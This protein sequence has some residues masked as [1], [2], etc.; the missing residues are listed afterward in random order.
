METLF[1][2]DKILI[3]LKIEDIYKKLNNISAGQKATALLI[4][5]FAQQNRILIIDQHEEDL[6]NRFIY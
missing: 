1:P 5:L 3:K 6:D 4:L 2:D